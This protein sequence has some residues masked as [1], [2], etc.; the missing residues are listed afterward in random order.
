MKMKQYRYMKK[1]EKA[2]FRTRKA[3]EEKSPLTIDE[4][5]EHIINDEYGKKHL[6]KILSKSQIAQFIRGEFATTK[7]RIDNKG[8]QNLYHLKEE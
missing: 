1:R 8:Y 4:I 7:I 6:K 5:Y 3:L 2:I